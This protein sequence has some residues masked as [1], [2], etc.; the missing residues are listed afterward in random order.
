MG[1]ETGWYHPVAGAFHALVLIL[2]WST[3]WIVA[4]SFVSRRFIGLTAPYVEPALGPLGPLFMLYAAA[5][6]VTVMIIWIRHKDT[7][8]RHRMAY[9]IGGAVWVCLGMHD[10]L[11][12]QGLPTI[13]YLMEYGFFAFALAGVWVAFNSYLETAAEEKYRVITEYANDCILVIQ[14]GRVVFRNPSCYYLTSLSLSRAAARDLLDI[15]TSEDR[16]T[17]FEHFRTLLKGDRPPPPITV[18]I[19]RS[20]GEE[21][22]VDMASSLIRYRERPA[23]LSIM[24]DITERKRAE[25]ILRESEE[26]YRSMMETMHDSVYICSPDFRIVYMN[27]AMIKMMGRDVTGECC[28]QALFERDEPCPWCVHNSVR[29]GEISE[30]EMVSPRD[31]RSYHVTYSPVFHKAGPA[32]TMIIYRDITLTKRLEEQVLRSERLS[33]TGQLAATVAH[34][35]NSPLQGI[36]SLI[37]SL[38]RAYQQDERLLEKLSLLK[39][40]FMSIRNTVTRLLDLSRPGK[41]AKQPTN[42]N[43][44]IED[45]IGLLKSY[46]KKN[47]VQMILDLSPTIPNISASPQQLGHVLMNLIS[48]SVE[49]MDEASRLA[50][51]PKQG[52]TVDKGTDRKIAISSHIDKDNIVINVID[53]GP[54]IPEEHLKHIFEPFY[55]RKKKGMGI[56]LSI[57]HGII[58]DHHGVIEAENSPEGGAAFTIALPIEQTA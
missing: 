53:T 48:N 46:L 56:G 28:Y 17:V 57:C 50:Q 25:E 16:K 37:G 20:D 1:I 43:R 13:Q 19:R 24:R 26:K 33:A 39:R 44:T 18:R 3:H 42:I 32:S 10:G 4:D 40:A 27:S 41:E 34:E 8:P 9:L 11:A 51:H 58:L 49:A 29:Q 12:A 45:T 36:I 31:N 21:R 2:L 23:T 22:W 47:Q 7:N 38:E 35:I 52:G 30:V 54:G 55:T 14:D 15:V 6:G 5:A